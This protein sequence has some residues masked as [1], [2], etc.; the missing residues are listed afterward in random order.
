M[1]DTIS[2]V[3]QSFESGI[4]FTNDR[5]PSMNGSYDDSYYSLNTRIGILQR[6]TE[7][8][9][10]HPS[11]LEH[12]V[13][14]KRNKKFT[15]TDTIKEISPDSGQGDDV[16][17][18]AVD[19]ESEIM[20]EEEIDSAER[21]PSKQD[22]E[23]VED[24]D[25][26]YF[27][28][29]RRQ[30][31]MIICYEEEYDGA[32]TEEQ[33]IQR[34]KRKC[35]HENIIKEGLDLEIEDKSQSFDEK[36]YFVKVHLPWRTESRYAEVMNLKL[37]VKRFITISVKQEGDQQILGNTKFIR[38][39]Y[40]FLQKQMQNLK[41]LT[42]YNVNI[43]E[44][45]PSFYSATAGGK[46]EEQFIVKD[47]MTHYTNAQRSGIVFQILLRAKYDEGEKCGIRRLLND[48][49]YSA[50]FPLHEGR[51][52]KAH[53]SGALLDRKVRGCFKLCHK[54]KLKCCSKIV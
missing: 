22:A 38:K 17:L 19:R 29:G 35:F 49:T 51:Y 33:A 4:S 54:F 36:T 44:R 41:S 7:L 28:D 26:L 43:I 53:P 12:K 16:S 30:I 45:E 1:I 39:L 37:P 2:E 13:S 21:R 14:Y 23:L 34:E 40:T 42:M 10:M 47:R 18:Y 50:C 15:S 6:F 52:D 9:S 32:M 46:R 31:D 5:R 24:P 27:R 8:E 20:V 48:G 3:S 25:S 11:A